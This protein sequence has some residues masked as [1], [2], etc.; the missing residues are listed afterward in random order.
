MGLGA[1]LVLFTQVESERARDGARRD[2]A[3]VPRR[4]MQRE[5]HGVGGME[6]VWPNAGGASA[7]ARQWASRKAQRCAVESARGPKRA[8]CRALGGMACGRWQFA[9]PWTLDP[10]HRDPL[11]GEGSKAAMFLASLGKRALVRRQMPASNDDLGT[12]RDRHLAWRPGLVMLDRPAS[13]ERGFAE[14]RPRERH[15]RQHGRAFIDRG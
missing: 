11:T 1:P 12:S 5:E 4:A 10:T 2:G 8:S 9:P 7:R 3:G 13:I 15:D 14:L 6:G